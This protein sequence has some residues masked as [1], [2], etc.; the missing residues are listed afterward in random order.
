ML[1]FIMITLILIFLFTMAVLILDCYE[2]VDSNA[3]F[4][5]TGHAALEITSKL[6]DLFSA[7]IK[8]LVK[9]L[10]DNMNTPP[11][12]TPSASPVP[13]F[14]Q[15]EQTEYVLYCTM[16]L[17]CLRNNYTQIGLARPGSAPQHMA[18]T[19]QKIF[20]DPCR[21]M[22]YRYLFDRSVSLDGGL[23]AI[24]AA[25]FP[26]STFPVDRM[27]RH[28]NSVLEAYCLHH[29]LAPVVVSNAYDVHNGRV[30]IEISALNPNV[31]PVGGRSNV[32]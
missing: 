9:A 24:K 18:P 20:N 17:E 6:W 8:Y 21:G 2:L 4:E 29:H 1:D 15:L 22:V 13:N 26:L 32:P 30:C 10:E 19:G 14:S 3:V 12:P 28:L 25:E 31:V 23:A 7:L 16:L 11:L 5:V 27:A